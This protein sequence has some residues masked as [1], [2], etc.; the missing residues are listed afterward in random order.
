ML[1]EQV[2]N[3]FNHLLNILGC[4]LAEDKRVIMYLNQW[5]SVIYFI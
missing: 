3:A 2:T 5:L 1:N 4:E